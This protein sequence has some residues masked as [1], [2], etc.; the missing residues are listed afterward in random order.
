MYTHHC[1]SVCIRVRW[2]L[3]QAVFQENGSVSYRI[4]C[5]STLIQRKRA[6]NTIT[7]VSGNP[8][9]YFENG[10]VESSAFSLYKQRKR[11]ELTCHVITPRDYSVTNVKLQWTRLLRRFCLC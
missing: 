3:H 4:G 8:G 9:G 6:A 2:R 1:N 11:M 5:L 7:S 10:I